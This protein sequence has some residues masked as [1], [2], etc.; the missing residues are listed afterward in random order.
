[1][2]NLSADFSPLCPAWIDNTYC[3]GYYDAFTISLI[4]YSIER[5]KLDTFRIVPETKILAD[6]T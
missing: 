1:M 6:G 5:I 2:Q 4:T 3:Y